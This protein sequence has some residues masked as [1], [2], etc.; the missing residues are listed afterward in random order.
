MLVSMPPMLDTSPR[1]HGQGHC[2]CEFEAGS[3]SYFVAY[4]ASDTRLLRRP[5]QHAIVAAPASA[6]APSSAG[7]G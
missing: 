1:Y 2:Q 3:R 5:A 7:P 6:P 4:T